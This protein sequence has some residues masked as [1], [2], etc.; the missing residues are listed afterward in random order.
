VL[1]QESGLACCRA[2]GAAAWRADLVD[3]LIGDVKP[4]ET[5]LSVCVDGSVTK[6][7]AKNWFGPFDGRCVPCNIQDVDMVQ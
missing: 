1:S 3:R 6:D 2:L 4:H 5:V 7:H